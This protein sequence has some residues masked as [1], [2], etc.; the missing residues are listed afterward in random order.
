M[1]GQ[2]RIDR[3]L[4]QQ[5]RTPRRIEEAPLPIRHRKHPLH[6][7]KP[8]TC[9]EKLRIRPD[10]TGR[11]ADGLF[12]WS[13]A[14]A[15]LA[16][17]GKA[18][19]LVVDAPFGRKTGTRSMTLVYN[20]S[21]CLL[22]DTAPKPTE[23]LPIYPLKT[24][25]QVPDGAIK[26]K[27]APS[28]E[29]GGKRYLVSLTVASSSISP[30]SYGGLVEIASPVLNPVRSP[31]TVSRSE[32][33]LWVPIAWGALGAVAGFGLFAALR[34]FKGNNLRVSR[35]LLA[36]AA[37]I[38]LI[39]GAI[40]ALLTSYLNQDVWTSSANG[41][42]AAAIGFTASTSGVMTALLAAVWEDP[43]PASGGGARGAEG[44]AGGGGGRAG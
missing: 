42:A 4:R 23:P 44:G 17:A 20:I 21:G 40:T 22:A 16:L 41:W 26:L 7:P 10:G 29:N 11:P 6:L 43:E 12:Q 32:N 15:T 13:P 39:V 2:Q 35:L 9:R 34:F 30:G 37:V 38:S 36:V 25:D 19:E 5:L 14:K 18:D 3:I 28:I 33:R 1:L 8:L 31:V 24:G 27:R